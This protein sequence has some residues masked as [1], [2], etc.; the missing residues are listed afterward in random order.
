MFMLVHVTNYI[1]CLMDKWWWRP[2]AFNHFLYLFCRWPLFLRSTTLTVVTILSFL[3]VLCNPVLFFLH[4]IIALSDL[5]FFYFSDAP[6]SPSQSLPIWFSLPSYILVSRIP[7][8]LVFH[9][10]GL[11][12]CRAYALTWLPFLFSIDLPLQ[13]DLLWPLLACRPFLDWH[14]T[15]IDSH[16]FTLL[17]DLAVRQLSSNNP[18]DHSSWLRTF[19]RP[20][21]YDAEF[22]WLESQ[23]TFP[24]NTSHR[25]NMISITWL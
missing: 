11:S 12:T 20:N 5:I 7:P 9:S 10:I 23:P 15:P 2:P 8:W 21:L 14:S 4:E 25:S 17:S 1:H 22:I 6:I 16:N 18:F 24:S 3:Q 13:S 19:L